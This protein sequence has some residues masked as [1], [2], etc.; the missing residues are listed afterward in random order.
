MILIG[1]VADMGGFRIVFVDGAE[2]IAGPVEN[3][4]SA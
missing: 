1:N 2:H 3:D 4:L